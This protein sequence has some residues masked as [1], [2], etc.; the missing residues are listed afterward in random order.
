MARLPFPEQVNFTSTTSTRIRSRE[1]IFSL[2]DRFLRVTRERTIKDRVQSIITFSSNVTRT[3]LS[4]SNFVHG[5]RLSSK[6]LFPP[7][8]NSYYRRNVKHK[9][10]LI[11]QSYQNSFQLPFPFE[12][13][14]WFALILDGPLFGCGYGIFTTSNVR[15]RKL[16]THTCLRNFSISFFLLPPSE[17]SKIEREAGLRFSK[18]RETIRSEIVKSARR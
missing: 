4:A 7:I 2:R 9:E 11:T 17:A 3:F 16:I 12:L 15:A 10:Y 8:E 1:Y 6:W 5:S 18:H 14:F 13:P